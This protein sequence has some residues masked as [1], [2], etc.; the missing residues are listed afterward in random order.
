MT[1]IYRKQP[2]A[3]HIILYNFSIVDGILFKFSGKV[4]DI[5]IQNIGKFG[6]HLLSSS[7]SFLPLTA[8]GHLELSDFLQSW[9]A[10]LF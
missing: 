5:E 6:Q 7:W 8:E 1:L 10:V 9:W 3:D 2:S 4:Y